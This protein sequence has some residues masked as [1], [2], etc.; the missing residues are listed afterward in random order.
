MMEALKAVPVTS[1]D[2]AAIAASA[3]AGVTQSAGELSPEATD[4]AAEKINDIA[5][6]LQS[7]DSADESAVLETSK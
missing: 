1:T 7:A 2:S 5:N 4:N 3:I 6:F